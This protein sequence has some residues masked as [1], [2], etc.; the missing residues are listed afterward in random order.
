VSDA[1]DWTQALPGAPLR[2]RVVEALRGLGDVSL[3]VS[4]FCR[5]TSPATRSSALNRAVGL[6]DELGAYVDA[7]S[8]P[9]GRS[10]A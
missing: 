3:E 9:S 7:M 4:R 5:A 1:L 6:L 10:C 2:P 8:C